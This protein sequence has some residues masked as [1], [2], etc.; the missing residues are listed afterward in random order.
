MSINLNEPPEHTTAATIESGTDPKTP[1][2][3]IGV[4]GL[5]IAVVFVVFLALAGLAYWLAS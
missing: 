1:A 3:A 4:V 5:I 2:V